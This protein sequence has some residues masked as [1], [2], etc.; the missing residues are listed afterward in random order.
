[1]KVIHVNVVYNKGSTG[2]IVCDVHTELLKGGIDSVICY[3]RGDK[4]T[5]ANV[6]KTCGE[7]YSKFNNLLS[8]ITGIMYGGC[9]F[10]TNRLISVIKTEKPDIVH[11]HCLNGY[12]VNIYRLIS[13]LKK[14]GIK[15]VLTLHAEFM[16]T[17]NCSHALECD[18]WKSGCGNCPRLKKET[19][20]LFF[21][22][23]HT[24]WKRM[25]QAFDGFDNLV[26]T[27]V[28]P[29]LMERAKTS[30]ILANKPH[31]VVMN[32]L[33]T[34]VF[35]VRDTSDLKR[36]NGIKDEKIIFHATPFFTDDPTH[37]KGGHHIIKL[38]EKLPDIRFF[39]AGD[40]PENLT[41][42]K[43]VTLLGRISNQIELAA[44]YSMADLTV[45]T[46]KKETFS[47]IC[48]ESLSCGTPVVGFEAGAP[49][50]ISIPEYSDFVKY[51]NL[52]ELTRA[53]LN[54]L[55]TPSE[56]IQIA[57]AGQDIYSKNK[58]VNGYM[59]IYRSIESEEH[60]P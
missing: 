38:A 34:N 19:K 35:C 17:A 52:N 33:D 50:Q 18:K 57:R 7:L 32:G 60:N 16:H 24:S 46:S 44:F 43:N 59:Q 26:L 37:L 41:V 13:W 31:Y 56:R 27:S 6:Y 4:T 36:L 49:E 51:G 21:D 1:M 8:R 25:K 48:A 47:M 20:S 29:W 14:S 5:D 40:C 9:F 2:K 42:P 22:R 3:G 58:M 53:V 11:L 10:S 15:T 39:V 30:P 45:I 55:N 12:F 54:R 28:S 23:T